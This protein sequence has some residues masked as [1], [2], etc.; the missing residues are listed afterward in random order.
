MV[1]DPNGTPDGTCARRGQAAHIRVGSSWGVTFGMF[2]VDLRFS[3]VAFELVSDLIWCEGV[4]VGVGARGSSTWSGGDYLRC[5]LGREKWAN[6]W[7]TNEARSHTDKLKP[8]NHVTVVPNPLSPLRFDSSVDTAPV[9][10]SCCH[11]SISFRCFPS[12]GQW[13]SQ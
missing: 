4:G 7:I 8:P 12:A 6:L 13:S 5:A 3:L 11:V 2:G 9:A 10:R 1:G